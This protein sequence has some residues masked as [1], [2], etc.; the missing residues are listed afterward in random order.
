MNSLLSSPYGH[1][2]AAPEKPRSHVHCSLVM[3]DSRLDDEQS[4]A[5]IEFTDTPKWL[6]DLSRDPNG[7]PKKT[8]F[9]TLWNMT[10]VS[11]SA[12][13]ED[14]KTEFI[15]AVINGEERTNLFYPEM[16]AEFKDVNV[17]IQ[18]NQGRTALHWASERALFDMVRLCLS[19][20]DCEI[21]L[22]DNNGLTAFDLSLRGG[23][24]SET[25][26]SLFYS[27]IYE[28]E[29]ADPQGALLRVLTVT[30]KSDQDKPVFPGEAL[31]DPVRDQN[32]LLVAAL[33]DRRVD[34]TAR[35]MDGNTAL[36]I[37]AA[38]V[39]NA[40]IATKLLVAG[41]DIDALGN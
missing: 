41:A 6:Q 7:F 28:M 35:D 1:D 40:E 30:S 34:L 18:D 22:K 13:D 27:S 16:L 14:G 5:R 23:S 15:R 26:P 11:T 2:H 12:V 38:Q 3:T 36:H 4:V 29:E 10:G 37:A 20:P 24:G 32:S 8:K 21:G 33:I 17:N 19:V 39:N 9:G 31:F 25:I